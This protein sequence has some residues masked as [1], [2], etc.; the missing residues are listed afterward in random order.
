MI[1]NNLIGEIGDNTMQ[2]LWKETLE[3]LAYYGKTVSD[4]RFIEGNGYEIKL[5]NFMEIASK[6]NY[7]DGYGWQEVPIDLKIVGDNW[8]LERHEYDG[9]EWWEYKQ[10]PARP[11]KICHLLG[12]DRDTNNGYVMET[13]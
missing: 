10:R 5:E 4:I 13:L 2:N 11:A 7:D 6:Y 12:F 8:W 3:D 9:S 1:Q